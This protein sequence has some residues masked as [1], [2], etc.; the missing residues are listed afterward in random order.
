[1]PEGHQ[2][3]K[4]VADGIAAVAGS[5]HQLVNLS[6]RQVLALPVIG[7]LGSTTANCRPFRL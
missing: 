3:Q 5:S 6:F 1:M 7:V 4:P 2:D